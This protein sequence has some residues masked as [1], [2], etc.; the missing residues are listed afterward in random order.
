MEREQ[1]LYNNGIDGNVTT[2]EGER[3]KKVSGDRKTYGI[4]NENESKANDGQKWN[5]KIQSKRYKEKRYRRIIQTLWKISI[6][7]III[8]VIRLMSL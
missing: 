5:I 2:N 7:I 4:E 8:I 1:K 3:K 6:S